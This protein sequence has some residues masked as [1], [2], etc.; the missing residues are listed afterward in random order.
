MNEYQ[1]VLSSTIFEVVGVVELPGVG[2]DPVEFDGLTVDGLP[3]HVGDGPQDAQGRSEPDAFDIVEQWLQRERQ[4][5][6]TDVDGDRDAVID[7]QRGFAATP[8]GFVLDVVV[9]EEGVVVQLERRRGRQDRLEVAAE[10]EADR[11]ASA[12]RSAFPPRSG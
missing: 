7:V 8:P 5:G 10:P 9:D 3:G 11:D 4:H 6:V 12:G 1:L 2:P